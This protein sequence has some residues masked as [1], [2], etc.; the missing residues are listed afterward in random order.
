MVTR[1]RGETIIQIK[2]ATAAFDST[3]TWPP[4]RPFEIAAHR[5]RAWRTRL[6]DNIAN[7]WLPFFEQDHEFFR[8]NLI[9]INVDFAAACV[10]A[11]TLTAFW[12]IYGTIPCR[13][14]KSCSVLPPVRRSCVAPHNLPTPCG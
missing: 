7:C 6:L 13:I 5:Q 14:N 3:E 10:L 4:R 8:V 11:L 2:S 9:L 12:I 1:R